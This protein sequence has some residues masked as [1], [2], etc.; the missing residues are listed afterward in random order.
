M[1]NRRQK[2]S[3]LSQAGFELSADYFDH[4]NHYIMT[5]IFFF[6]L[7]VTYGTDDCL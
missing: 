2:E 7:F 6:F 5:F 3:T 4:D 1:Q